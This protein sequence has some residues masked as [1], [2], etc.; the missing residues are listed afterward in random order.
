M[1]T[2]FGFKK[3]V[4]IRLFIAVLEAVV[5]RFDRSELH[6]VIQL[7]GVGNVTLRF[8]CLRPITLPHK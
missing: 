5:L 6:F 8:L 3:N 4:N 1:R 2:L 7:A